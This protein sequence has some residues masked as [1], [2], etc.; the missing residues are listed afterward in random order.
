[1]EINSPQINVTILRDKASSL[2]ITAA[3]IENAF[4]FSYSYNYV[5]RIET[6]IDQYNV[7]LELYGQISN[8]HRYFNSLWM[9]SAISNDWSQWGL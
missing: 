1:M 5:T 4:M 2:G 7:I 6:A 9:R 8:G 3:D